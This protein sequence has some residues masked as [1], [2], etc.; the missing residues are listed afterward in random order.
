MVK[1]E[2]ILLQI[3]Q[4]YKTES[5]YDFITVWAKV[6]GID[7]EVH[8][9]SGN[10]VYLTNY[11]N[12]TSFAGKQVELSFRLISDGSEQSDGWKIYNIDLFKGKIVFQPAT[13]LKSGISLLGIGNNH[14]LDILNV[15]AEAFPDAVFVEFTVKDLYGNFVPGLTEADFDIWDDGS[16]MI[17][18]KKIMEISGGTMKPAVDIVFIMD[19]SGSMSDDQAKVKSAID[20]LLPLLQSDFD[21]NVGLIRFAQLNS[22]CPDYGLLERG[23]NN[24]FFFS[25]NNPS[26]YNEFKNV[27]WQRNESSGAYEPYYEVLN[28]TVNQ[29]IPYRSHSQKIFVILGDESATGTNGN[30][31][32]NFTT[33][34]SLT[35]A[36]VAS[37][38]SSRGIQ[39]FPIVSSSYNSQWDQI[40]SATGGVIQNISTSD[41]SDLV[42][43]ISGVLE[44]KYILRYCLNVDP[45]QV[46]PNIPH[47]AKVGMKNDPGASDTKQYFPIIT[48]SI[49][50]TIP[51]QRL[52]DSR[53]PDNVALPINITVIQNN[54]TLNYVEFYYR[55]ADESSFT[56]VTRTANQGVTVGDN[57]NFSFTISNDKALPPHVEYYCVAVLTQPGSTQQV[58]VSSPPDNHIHF[59]W[60]IAIRPNDPPSITNIT[61]NPQNPI[62]CQPVTICARITDTT[63]RL[64]LYVPPTLSYRIANTPSVPIDIEMQHQGNNI[65]CATI[66]A[67]AIQEDDLEYWI[68]ATDNYGTKGYYGDIQNPKIL[69]LYDQPAQTTGHQLDLIITNYSHVVFGCDAMLPT[70]EIKAYYINDCGDEQ[71]AGT[72]TWDGTSGSFSFTIY[73]DANSN[74]MIKDGFFNNE[75]IILKLIRG[76]MD[77]Q[78]TSSN[79]SFTTSRNYLTLSSAVGPGAP[80]L[81]VTGNNVTIQ[82]NSTSTSTAD[83]TK[84]ESTQGNLLSHSFKVVNS[85]CEDLL[86]KQISIN[87]TN[88]FTLSNAPGSFIALSPG[89]EYSFTVNYLGL[90]NNAPATVTINT[91]DMSNEPFKFNVLGTTVS[92]D[93]CDGIT[94]S[95]PISS[96]YGGT[97]SINIPSNNTS[98]FAYILTSSG[99]YVK[100]VFENTNSSAGTLTLYIPPTGLTPGSYMMIINRNG[101]FCSKM[102]I[103]Q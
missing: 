30:V 49:V 27:I 7:R 59:A 52:S 21:A 43:N 6:D 62:P 48:P 72:G 56:K 96:M 67:D 32:P 13:K 44:S 14:Q 87:N 41:Y 31:C 57:V 93:P 8:R 82:N 54:H 34:S 23:T 19:N 65:Y 37:L 83:N 39:T 55:Q 98:V 40:A 102:F 38:L 42:D 90:N 17:G 4:S 61:V 25:L 68:T 84:F 24:N 20:G 53:Q 77:F 79:I 103:V 50:R 70:D 18:C 33:P 100:S 69:T 73:G 60:T 63:E 26:E 92:S 58:T 71:L 89:Q 2:R 74:D 101:A 85:G 91:S 35:E 86:L 99:I 3:E 11:V 95:N 78:L 94:L 51:T 9:T 75:P 28:W 16:Q 46:D 12:L 15:N 10:G 76:G 66:P 5:Q 64:N 97:L 80:K 45:S 47:E 81:G 88:D 1:G 36:S 29:N 22:T